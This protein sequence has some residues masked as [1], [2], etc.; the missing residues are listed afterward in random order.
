[1]PRCKLLLLETGVVAL[2]EGD[3]VIESL[4]FDADSMARSYMDVRNGV[5]S[6]RLIQMVEGLKSRGYSGATNEESLLAMLREHGLEASLIAS[7]EQVALQ[8]K[9]VGI[10]L[11]AKFAPSEFEAMNLLR[12]FAIDLSSIKVAQV[13]A[14]RDQHVIQS[15]NALDELDKITNIMGARVREWYG[16]HFPELDGM[17][18]SLTAYCQIV[19]R[20]GSR[21]NIDDALLADAGLQDKADTILRAAGTSKGGAITDENFRVLQRMAEHTNHLS[22]LRD[23]LTTHLEMEMDTVAP[24][25]K[26]ILGSTIGARIIAKVGSLDRLAMLPASTI[27]VLGAEKALFRALKSGTRP[28]KHGIIFQHTLVHSAPKWQRGKIARAI[29]AKV[30]MAA[31]LDAYRGTKDPTLLAKLNQR[32]EEI[33]EKYKE[34]VER[35]EGEEEGWRREAPRMRMG[36]RQGWREGRRE[37]RGFGGERRGF[38]R[39]RKEFGGERRTFGGERK[40]SGGERGKKRGWRGH[41][42]RGR[43][44]RKSRRR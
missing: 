5:A 4:R 41:R 30:A 13:S 40:E 20:G 23:S 43:E 17:V 33:R 42:R 39:E 29:A 36:G 22:A 18:Q 7:D 34:P 1:M 10:M 6:D 38:G 8:E 9:K 2:D 32:I 16:L 12:R 11:E 19:S 31:R 28:P 37:R 14:K 27:Q 25:V 26:E 15:V 21:K 35:E 44:R 3:R 24:N